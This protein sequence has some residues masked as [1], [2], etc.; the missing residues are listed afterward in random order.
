MPHVCRNL[1]RPGKDVLFP[2]AGTLDAG[3]KLKPS[4]FNFIGFLFLYLHVGTCTCECRY[5]RR[6][7]DGIRSPGPGVTASSQPS[8]KGTRN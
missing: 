2:G 7:E 1:R 5:L 4:V 3:T 8:N 6:P